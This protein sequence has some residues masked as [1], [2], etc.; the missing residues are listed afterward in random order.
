E[1]TERGVV[2]G[3]AWELL[4]SSRITMTPLLEFAWQRNP[5]GVAGTTKWLTAAL[6]FELGLGWTASLYGTLRPVKDKTIPDRYTDHHVGFSVGYDL[7]ALLKREVRWLNGLTIE[8]GYKHERVARANLN[9][10]GVQLLY[11]RSF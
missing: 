7:G 6:G 5:G 8:A 2:A 4:L 10:I 9:T 3:F 11:E 1:P